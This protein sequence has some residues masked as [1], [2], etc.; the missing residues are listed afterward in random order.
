MWIITFDDS[1]FTDECDGLLSSYVRKKA[2]Y[3]HEVYGRAAYA[4]SIKHIDLNSE[5]VTH[6]SDEGVNQ[7]NDE[8]SSY[9]VYLV[10][11]DKEDGR[12]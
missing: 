12:W 5:I 11:S 6:V 9:H 3:Y 1:P 7:F 4:V 10:Q 2:E 8:L